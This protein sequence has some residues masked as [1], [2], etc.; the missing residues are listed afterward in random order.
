MDLFEEKIQSYI[1]RYELIAE[2]ETV[3]VAFSGGADSMALLNALVSLGYNCRAA[4]CNFH[5][6]G[7]ESNRDMRH[8]IHMA[9]KLGVDYDVIDFDVESYK[10]EHGVSTE[11]ACRELR[12]EWFGKLKEQHN[13]A[14]IAVAHHRNDNIETMLLNLLRGTGITGLTGMKPRHDDIIRPMLDCTRK[15]VEAYLQRTKTDYVTD[16]TNLE[17]DVKR[18]KLRNLILPEIYAQFPDAE[19]TISKT[20]ENLRLNLDLYSAGIKALATKYVSGNIIKLSQLIV[21]QKC[22]STL[23]FEIIREYGFNASQAEDIISSGHSGRRFESSTHYAVID[24][25]RLLIYPIK[26]DLSELQEPQPRQ[27]Y[28]ITLNYNKS[29]SYPVNLTFEEI[30]NKDITFDRTGQTL[31]LDASA[32]E[33]N[34][35]FEVRRWRNGDKMRPYGMKGRKLV[36]DILSDAKLSVID[37]ENIWV[38]T[39]NEEILWV[40]GLRTSSLFPVTPTTKKVVKICYFNKSM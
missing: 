30:E 16:S 14:V 22:A 29:A 35:S 21:E 32:M 24:R 15:D 18:N 6:R 8:A 2:D 36:S 13:P 25:G 7:E 37:K 19:N 17:N 39:R 4:H 26:Q 9:Q 1:R 28:T 10:K 5:L 27:E 31:Y 20:I 23:L 40:I 3:I 38:L 34:A 11:M 12:Y 33:G